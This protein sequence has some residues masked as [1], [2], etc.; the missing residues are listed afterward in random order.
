MVSDAYALTKGINQLKNTSPADYLE[1][2][3]LSGKFDDY[4]LKPAKISDA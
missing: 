2:T 1:R 4:S 3:S